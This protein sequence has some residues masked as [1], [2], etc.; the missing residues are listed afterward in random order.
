MTSSINIA[1]IEAFAA[2]A[3]M[4][5]IAKASTRL[6]LSQPAITRR[7]KNLESQLSV[8][9]F[10]RKSRPMMLTPEGLKAYK[11]AT[12]VLASASELQAALTPGK[13]MSGDF[14]LGFSTSLGDTLLGQP[15]DTLR[16]EFPKLKLS[17]ICDESANLLLRI[18]RREIDTAI[19]LRADDHNL[20]KDIAGE[21]LCSD[22]IVVVAP[23]NFHFPKGAGL[24]ELSKQPWILNP[25]GCSGRELLQSAF[26]RA[27][28]PLNIVV[29]TSGTGLQM[30]LIESGRGLGAFLAYV[31]KAS[32]F[33]NSIRV[34]RPSDFGPR[35]SIWIAYHPASER[36]EQPIRAVRMA[37]KSHAAVSN[38]H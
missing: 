3:E 22:S 5:S 33:R 27:G 18:Q 8:K 36:L 37:L 10:D 23:K 28:L 26:E 21:V 4:R 6:H 29:E 11:H 38:G 13:S 12:T 31:V 9:L 19:V 15:L 1:D 2:V 16:R 24:A 34:I 32:R 7:L 20:P 30:T 14:R 35:V 25:P 17:V